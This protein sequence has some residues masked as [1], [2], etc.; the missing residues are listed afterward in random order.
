MQRDFRC[1][2]RLLSRR[3]AI[4]S[5]EHF[6]AKTRVHRFAFVRV[7]HAPAETVIDFTSAPPTV[8]L[9][10]RRGVA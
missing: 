9:S 3:A 7:A 10:L 4:F 2:S 1:E 6:A 5:A 8:P